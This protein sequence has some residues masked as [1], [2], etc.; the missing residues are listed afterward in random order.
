V[1]ALSRT[2]TQRYVL[3]MIPLVTRRHV[4]YVRVTGMA[5]HRG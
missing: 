4:D 3:P 2:V 1:D 5:C